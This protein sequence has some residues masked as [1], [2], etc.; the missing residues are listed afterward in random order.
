MCLPALCLR[1]ACTC[2]AEAL[3]GRRHEAASGTSAKTHHIFFVV[4]LFYAWSFAPGAGRGSSRCRLHAGG[5]GGGGGDTHIRT[6]VRR[7]EEFVS[8]RSPGSQLCSDVLII[9][10]SSLLINDPSVPSCRASSSE[11]T[12]TTNAPLRRRC[13][14]AGEAN[15]GSR[16]LKFQDHVQDDQESV[17]GIGFPCVR[18]RIPLCVQSW[19]AR[20]E[21]FSSSAVSLRR[22]APSSPSAVSIGIHRFP[23]LLPP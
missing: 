6:H 20:C 9:R 23:L 18:T 5:G 22:T 7:T 1:L 15:E 14:A 13:R 11:R 16:P 8:R 21:R 12:G 10:I 4:V 3:R 19:R 2:R 17:N